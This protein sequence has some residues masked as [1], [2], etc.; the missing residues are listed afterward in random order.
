MLLPLRICSRPCLLR[1]ARCLWLQARSPV[2]LRTTISF[3][4][5]KKAGLALAAEERDLLEHLRDM[6]ESGKYPVAMGP[7][8]NPGAWRFD[9]PR[10]VDRVWSMLERLED[11]LRKTGKPCLPPTDLRRRYRPPGYDVTEVM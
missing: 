1:K 11:A 6:M 7:G 4:N 3:S 8:K 10:D 5:A 2:D 9:Y